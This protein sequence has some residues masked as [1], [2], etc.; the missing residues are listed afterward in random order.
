[1]IQNSLLWGITAE[2]SF[3]FS[4]YAFVLCH[5]SK[6]DRASQCAE[7]A[8]A[9][10]KKYNGKHSTIVTTALVLSIYTFRQPLQAIIPICMDEYASGMAGKFSQKCTSTRPADLWFD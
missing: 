1:M 4:S 3:A 5:F 2:T 8:Q 9:L 10:V 6:H 7:I